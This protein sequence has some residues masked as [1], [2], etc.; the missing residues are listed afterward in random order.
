[1]FKEGFFGSLTFKQT[2]AFLIKAILDGIFNALLIDFV[3]EIKV[4]FRFG[5]LKLSIN[6]AL[7]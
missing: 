5:W 2:Y 6:G 3:D 4:I 7:I 1:M